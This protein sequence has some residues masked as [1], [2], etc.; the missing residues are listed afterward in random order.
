VAGFK[1]WLEL[2]YCVRKGERAIRILAPMPVKPKQPADAESD[3]RARLLFRVVPVFD[4]SQVD[5]LD[6]RDQAPLEPPSQPLTGDSH[7]RLLTPAAKL[8]RELGYTVT[9]ETVPTGVGGWCDYQA[10]AI[11]I[12]ASAAPNAQLRTL[13]HEITHALGVDYQTYSRERAEV[14]VDSVTFIVCSG[15]GLA[16]DGDSVPYVAG[17]GE[18]GALDAVTQ[19]AQ[20]IDQHARRIETALTSNEPPTIASR[21]W[22]TVSI[23][24]PEGSGSSQ[25]MQR[26]PGMEGHWSPQPMVTTTSA[27]SASSRVRSC[28]TWSLRSMPSSRMTSMTSGWTWS[29]GVV[30]AESAWWA[31][32]AARVNRAW[33]IWERPAFWTFLADNLT[34]G[35]YVVEDRDRRSHACAR[36]RRM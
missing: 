3:D 6:G 7:A 34:G 15:F 31:P 17:W 36:R 29:A 21:I 19:F 33:L 4:R 27:C 8:A 25:S 35:G 20:L 16:V 32:S 1:A 5:P 9:F 30:P 14:I 18:D 28:G 2:G 13:I 26:L 24:W 11:V 22:R 23:G 10:N 12:D